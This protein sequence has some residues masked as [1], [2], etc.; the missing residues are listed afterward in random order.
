MG[1]EVPGFISPISEARARL[2][3]SLSEGTYAHSL[4]VSREAARWAVAF[5]ADPDAALW[6]G[7][8]HDCAKGLSDEQYLALAQTAGLEIFDAE[9]DAPSVLHQ[10]LGARWAAERFG[11]R[12]P[13]V[14]AA[15]GCHTTGAQV[16]DPLARCLFVVDWVSPDRTYEG[17]EVL[18]ATL[19]KGVEEGFAA[20]LRAKRDVVLAKG[21]PDHPWARAALDR[22][23]SD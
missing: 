9:R 15:I 5:G 12:D 16:M 18:R 11:V 21:L 17:V 4:A 10:R 13:A 3:E 1:R 20:V 7:L 23:T 6:A 8:L 19:A 22:W 14:L 2:R